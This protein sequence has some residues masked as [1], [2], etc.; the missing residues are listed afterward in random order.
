MR[1]AAQR[2]ITTDYARR[3]I[4]RIADTLVVKGRLSRTEIAALSDGAA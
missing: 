2:L 1:D 3:T 4:P